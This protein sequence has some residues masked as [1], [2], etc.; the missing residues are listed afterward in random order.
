M[1]KSNTFNFLLTLKNRP[2]RWGPLYYYYYYLCCLCCI[3]P[4]Y[5]DALQTGTLC[6]FTTLD[7]RLDNTIEDVLSAYKVLVRK[8]K[9]KTP[10]WRRIAQV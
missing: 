2:I 9:V 7:H 3:V 6:T 1:M 8:P 10:I 5:T 4:K